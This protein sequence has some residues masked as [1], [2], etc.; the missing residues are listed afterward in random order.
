[1]RVCGLRL[2]ALTIAVCF[3][4]TQALA[5][6]PGRFAVEV[7]GS[8]GP[9][10]DDERASAGYLVWIDG[11]AKLLVD[12]G[13]GT[14]LRFAEAGASLTG[15][16]GI[17]LTHFHADHVSD[18]PA[19]LKSGSF[20]GRAAE[21]PIVGPTGNE[22]FPRLRAF[23]EATFNPQTG[24]YRYLGGYLTGAGGLPKLTA[25]E[26]DVSREETT[27]VINAGPL[28]ADAIPVN[29]GDVPALAYVV[30]VDGAA[31]VFA[32]DQSRFSSYFEQALEN[33]QPALLIAHHAI[34]EGTGQPRG[35]H[36]APSSIGEMAA[37]LKARRLVL[38]HNMKRALDDLDTGLDAIRASYDGPVDVAVDHAC[39]TV[40]P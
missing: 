12:A 6:C 33:A 4:F 3:S 27:G 38:S 31:A 19:I 39:Y 1:M 35:L 21:L 8:G 25:S 29:H 40:L 22:Y 10:A 24:A 26:I 16:E 34:R 28:T 11:K 36:R 23:L 37:V 30:T 14:F 20:E 18:L 7:L 15:L 32:G 9:L 13:G 2:A 5:A 17:L